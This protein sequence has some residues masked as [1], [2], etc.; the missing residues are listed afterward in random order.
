MI[1]EY[2][3]KEYMRSLLRREDLAEYI[4]CFSS[5]DHQFNPTLIVVS[6]ASKHYDRSDFDKSVYAM[7]VTYSDPGDPD[8]VI[9]ITSWLCANERLT[10]ETIR[11]ELA[12]CLIAFCGITFTEE[13]GYEFKQ[14]LKRIN[15][16]DKVFADYM[17]YA[18]EHAMNMIWDMSEEEMRK[19]MN[20]AL[21]HRDRNMYEGNVALTEEWDRQFEL[22][23]LMYDGE[24]NRVK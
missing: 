24:K 1:T 5:E 16:N 19:E 14:M 22:W 11:H 6:F 3:A 9:E 15:P 12:H 8:P 10:K 13:H 4:S 21:F 2:Q 7:G 17:P 20:K 18:C 23:R